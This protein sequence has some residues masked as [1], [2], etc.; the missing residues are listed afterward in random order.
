MERH[1][2]GLQVDRLSPYLH[3]QKHDLIS[4]CSNENRQV[5]RAWLTRLL[6]VQIV[7]LSSGLSTR[8]SC[9]PGK[10]QNSLQA[11]RKHI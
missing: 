7:K 5:Q 6:Y 11:T 8:F 2:Y 10:E 3:L 4:N 9:S 1:V